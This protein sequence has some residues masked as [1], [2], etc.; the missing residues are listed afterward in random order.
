MAGKRN[1]CTQGDFIMGRSQDDR[2]RRFHILVGGRQDASSDS[3]AAELILLSLRSLPAFS[4]AIFTF[5]MGH[6]G[7]G[8]VLQSVG[9]IGGE[10]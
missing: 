1:E 2:Q 7:S 4:A 8:R 9:A 5:V 10:L 3:L 6:G